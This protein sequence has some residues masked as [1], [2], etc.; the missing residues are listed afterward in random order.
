MNAALRRGLAAMLMLAGV[1]AL[2]VMC[3]YV[4]NV[5]ATVAAI[6]LLLAVLLA[7][8][9]AKRTEAVVASIAG[10]LCLDCFFIPPVGRITIGDPRGWIVLG[11]FLSVSLVAT[12][13]SSRLHRQR[14]VLIARQIE[15]EKLY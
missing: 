5:G 6:V 1:V 15:S 12:N 4:L 2:A 8:A 3:A 9:Y 10:T 13:L 11:V 14:N 7:G